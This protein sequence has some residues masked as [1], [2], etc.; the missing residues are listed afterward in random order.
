MIDLVKFLMPIQ[1]KLNLIIIEQ[2]VDVET[3][4]KNALKNCPYTTHYIDLHL[5]ATPDY[6]LPEQE[7]KGLWVL[8]NFCSEIS[9]HTSTLLD[10]V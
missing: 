6:L 3:K 10:H 2:N 9:Q 7:I 5:N 4:V 1:D 8:S